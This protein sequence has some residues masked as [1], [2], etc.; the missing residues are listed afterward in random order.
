MGAASNSEKAEKVQS[1]RHLGG[2]YP[3]RPWVVKGKGSALAKL[4][5]DRPA[6]S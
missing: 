6:G 3:T 5:L 4:A 2:D 1:S